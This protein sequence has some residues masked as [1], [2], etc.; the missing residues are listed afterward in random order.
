MLIESGKNEINFAC[1]FVSANFYIQFKLY[2]MLQPFPLL[3]MRVF[4]V[5]IM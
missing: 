2:N 4:I 1:S 3:Y 5:Q